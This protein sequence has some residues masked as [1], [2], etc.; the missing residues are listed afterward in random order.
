MD[1]AMNNADVDS[2]DVLLTSGEGK[3]FSFQVRPLWI[4]SSW[5]QNKIDRSGVRRSGRYYSAE[6]RIPVMAE[7]AFYCKGQEYSIAISRKSLLASGKTEVSSLK[8]KLLLGD[9]AY[10]DNNPRFNT[11]VWRNGEMNTFFKRPGRSWNS[12]WD[13]GEGDY[14]QQG[15]NLNKANGVGRF[16]VFAHEDKEDDYYVVLRNGDFYQMYKGRERVM[17]YT[18]QA[19]GKG[20]LKVRFLRF[21]FKNHALRLMGV[22]AERII[23]IDSD[24]WKTYSGTVEKQSSNESL[25][26]D[27]ATENSEIMLDEAYMRGIK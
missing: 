21:T 16:E 13:L 11:K 22:Q 27:F 17:S 25:A 9:L 24:E 1:E 4:T 3:T 20:I 23:K 2:V 5:V 7:G 14:L 18:F 15:W 19:R 6:V 26:M 8:G 10:T 12:N